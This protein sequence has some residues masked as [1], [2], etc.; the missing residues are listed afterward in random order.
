MFVLLYFDYNTTRSTGL[1]NPEVVGLYTSLEKARSS[2]ND[3]L[4][5]TRESNPYPSGLFRIVNVLVNER[6]SLT[7]STG[8]VGTRER[9]KTTIDWDL[10]RTPF[11]YL[12][13]L[14]EVAYK[15]LSKDPVALDL[16][17]DLLG[18]STLE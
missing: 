2:A 11:F 1:E 15:I 3:Y 9:S 7:Y 17:K 4:N 18:V 14:D 16:V 13:P 5:D 8:R 10:V 6:K 12:P